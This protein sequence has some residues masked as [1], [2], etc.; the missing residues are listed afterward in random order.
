MAIYKCKMCG[1]Q[2]TVKPEH[3]IATCSHCGS[4]QTIPSGDDEQKFALYNRANTLRIRSAF[5]EAIVAYQS[6]ISIFPEEAEAYWGLCLS[7]YGIEYVDDKKTGDK[8]P[9]C[10]RI[11]YESILEDTDYLETLKFADVI[12]KDFYVSEAKRIDEIQRRILV[13]SQ[14]EK[15]EYKDN[16]RKQE[17]EKQE[18]LRIQTELNDS[19]SAVKNAISKVVTNKAKIQ[20]EFKDVRNIEAKRKLNKV[21]KIIA[22]VGSILTSAI[23]IVLFI[24]TLIMAVQTSSFYE[25]IKALLI[26]ISVFVGIALL[27]TLINFLLVFQTKK[28]IPTFVAILA[29][30]TIS[31][32]LSIVLSILYFYYGS[33]GPILLIIII[34][35]LIFFIIAFNIITLVFNNKVCETSFCT[36]INIKKRKEELKDLYTET[37]VYEKE[38]NQAYENLKA[39]YEKRSEL[40]PSRDLFIKNA[41]S[42]N[43]SLKTEKKP[44]RAKYSFSR[45]GTPLIVISNIAGIVGSVLTVLTS[46]FT[47]G[48]LEV[49]FIFGILAFFIT[50]YGIATL[51]YFIIALKKKTITNANF[52]LLIVDLIFFATFFGVLIFITADY[53]PSYYYNSHYNTLTVLTPL[54]FTFGVPSCIAKI[55]S[56]IIADIYKKKYQ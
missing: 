33:I 49:S 39:L 32:I 8:I 35:I 20:T 55:A 26:A 50:V 21:S 40:A 27:A 17:E 56:L 19:T 52:V 14:K 34:I 12:A 7:K 5:D 4:A 46:F 48:V 47:Y 51:I 10:H 37:D 45:R 31:F 9:T 3:K 28:N 54:I 41:E 13:I 16:L 1:A 53:Q 30:A 2:L 36:I 38:F 44:T 11:L 43:S 42:D 22:F 25:E 23:T 6:I 24:F 29:S 15:E 18:Q